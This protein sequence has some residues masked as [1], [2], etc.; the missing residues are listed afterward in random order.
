MMDSAPIRPE[1][2]IKRR[3]ALLIKGLEMI[4]DEACSEIDSVRRIITAYDKID[5]TQV[6]RCY[7]RVREA[8][9]K[10][11]VNY[12]DIVKCYREMWPNAASRLGRLEYQEPRMLNCVYA[13]LKKA[14]DCFK[15]DFKLKP[16]GESYESCVRAYGPAVE[17]RFID[18][19]KDLAGLP[20]EIDWGKKVPSSFPTKVLVL[21]EMLSGLLP[22]PDGKFGG[23]HPGDK[24]VST[25]AI[26]YVTGEPVF[27]FLLRKYLDESD[28]TRLKD[29]LKVIADLVM[30]SLKGPSGGKENARPR[31][32]QQ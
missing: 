23:H 18:I 22:K 12:V 10:V 21:L 5:A 6:M 26:E 30:R 27:F 25:R 15:H 29:C 7:D 32:K 24:E 3:E 16:K 1:A 8:V 13:V 11:I 31:S 20:H 2:L 4:C 9:V 19:L 28:V 14:G 17:D